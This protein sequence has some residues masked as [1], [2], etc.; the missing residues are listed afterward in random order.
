MKHYYGYIYKVTHVPTGRYYIGLHKGDTPECDGYMGSGTVWKK[1][2]L[3]HPV[4]EFRKEVL[5]TAKTKEELAAKEKKLISKLFLSDPLCKNCIPGGG[6]PPSV[7][8]MSDDSKKKRVDNIKKY[9]SSQRS[10]DH[11]R[12]LSERMT[13]RQVSK[14]TKAKISKARSGIK[15]TVETRRK[16]S[17][18][19]KAR[20]K[21][22]LSDSHKNRIS[23]SIKLWH[24]KRK[25]ANG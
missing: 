20:P 16:M 21:R 1:I 22:T 4:V 24:N 19:A 23:E 13:G 12:T 7:N 10:L 18:S 11:K 2:L 17:E 6:T 15:P 8:D 14:S 9:W 5:A 3:N 25:G